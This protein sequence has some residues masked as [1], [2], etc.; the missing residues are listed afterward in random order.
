MSHP[1]LLVVTSCTG[2]KRFKPDNPL[3]LSDFRDEGRLQE[4]EKALSEFTVPAAEMYAGQQHLLVMEGVRLLREAFGQKSIDLAIL[5]AGYGLISEDRVIAPYDVT[6]QTMKA[7]EIDEWGQSLG[8]RQA[9]EI[10]IKDYDLILVLL[11]E[12]YL[13]SLALPVQTRADQTLVFLA[14]HGSKRYVRDS[15]AK[16]VILPLSNE[17]AKQFRCSLI[18]LKGWI[19]R[20]FA[21][22]SIREP[23]WLQ[24]AWEQPQI[25]A[26]FLQPSQIQLE[27][28]LF[29]PEIKRPKNKKSRRK[30]QQYAKDE[31]IPIPDDIPV[32]PNRNFGMQYF[33]PDWEDRVD[34]NYDFLRDS[35]TPDRNSYFDDVYAHEIFNGAANYDG[36]LVSKTVLE[37]RKKHWEYLNG[38]G[39]HKFLRFDGKIMGDCG[40]FNY[41]KQEK[42][43]FETDEI[44]DYYERL[45]F[46]YGVSIDHLIVGK[47]AEEGCREKRYEL[48]LNN[49]QEF[50]EKHRE[51]NRKF[52][53]IGAVQ[54]WNPESY[55]NAVNRVIEMG[56]SDIAL[57]GLARSQTGEI[58]EIL[59]VV[60]PCLKPD[61]KL[62]LF[63]VARL[64]AIAAFRHLG[65]TSFDSAAPLRQAWLDADD[66]YHT[67]A[68]KYAAVRLPEVKTSNVRIKR[69]LESG[70]ADLETL[71]M[72]E[73]EAIKAMR[74]FDAGHLSVEETLEKILAYDRLLELPREGKVDPIKADNRVK[75]HETLYRELL[76]EKPWQQCN[77]KICREI[78]IEVVI[79]RNN[80]RNRRR[81]FHNT[82]VFYKH[83]KELI[84]SLDQKHLESVSKVTEDA[85]FCAIST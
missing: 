31:L 35:H 25:F 24:R 67:K 14:S 68:K 85:E 77:C 7:S 12:H 79:F 61:T 64:N 4:R 84:Q 37:D 78:G 70:I 49:A 32:A 59:K 6:F 28:P 75:K 45:G 56:Y 69:I 48:T 22:V 74:E 21:K 58:L 19:F 50:L 72:L 83:F 34:P 60:S 57:G 41:I 29:L 1:R 10:T 36:V 33:I 40:A 8:I 15:S 66:N 46:D 63:G 52:I 17:E 3:T 2:E 11:G 71:T 27:L 54:G 82:Y 81:G 51:R 43:P 39:I 42:P 13:R 80:N 5:S 9:F 26:D 30:Y 55:A 23:G 18:G 62:H 73:A 38:V 16:T 65:V 44:I 76:L 20:E 47:F 53:P